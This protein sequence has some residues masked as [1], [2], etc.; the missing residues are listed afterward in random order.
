M[1]NTSRATNL[2]I[3]AVVLV[4]LPLLVTIATFG[5]NLALQ[6][7]GAEVSIVGRL[8]PAHAILVGWCVVAVGV[9]GGLIASIFGEQHHA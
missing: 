8:G 7:T 5:A 4:I 2:S 1:T 9:V 6:T 3:A